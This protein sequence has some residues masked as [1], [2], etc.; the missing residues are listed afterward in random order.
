MAQENELVKMHETA[1][2]IQSGHKFP[3]FAQA[4]MFYT[5]GNTYTGKMIAPNTI[6]II[7]VPTQRQLQYMVAN[8]FLDYIH[9]V[10]FDS[11]ISMV[12]AFHKFCND[13]NEDCFSIDRYWLEFVME[14][15]HQKK[16]SSDRQDWI[17]I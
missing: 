2:E 3:L 9:D 4:K 8:K 1:V 10:K 15:K 11:T 7:W 13:R 12:N 5:D 6:K 14:M 17:K 16:W